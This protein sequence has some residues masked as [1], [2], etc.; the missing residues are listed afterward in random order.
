MKNIDLKVFP[1]YNDIVNQSE[2]EY[3]RYSL[4]LPEITSYKEASHWHKK[5]TS[6]YVIIHLLSAASTSP[7]SWTAWTE[8]MESPQSSTVRRRAWINSSRQWPTL[9]PL[10]PEGPPCSLPSA[11]IADDDVFSD[12]ESKCEERVRDASTD[13]Y[14]LMECN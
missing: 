12:G 4:N 3:R 8:V 6:S 13:L 1:Q 2:F 9:E 7:C 11:S 5:L 10:D 14:P